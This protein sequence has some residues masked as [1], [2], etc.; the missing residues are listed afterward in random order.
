MSVLP[1]SVVT[2]ATDGKYSVKFS[3]EWKIDN[4]HAYYY[5]S[6]TTEPRACQ[7]E[8]EPFSSGQQDDSLVWSVKVQTTR[9]TIDVIQ[10]STTG[11]AVTADFRCF[12]LDSGRQRCDCIRYDSFLGGSSGFGTTLTCKV[13]VEQRLG[14]INRGILEDHSQS[15]LPNGSLTLCLEI[16]VH[17]PKTDE[18]Q[19]TSQKKPAIEPAKADDSELAHDLGSLLT[20]G[21]LSNVTIVAGG[22]EFKAHKAIL[23]ARSPVFRAMFEHDMREAI[24]NQVTIED[25]S[26]EVVQE[27]LTFVYTG[28]SPNLKGMS[29]DLL[30]AADKYDLKQ[31]KTRSERELADRLT[32]GN[33]VET[34]LLAHQHS[35][36]ELMT[37]CMEK[38]PGYAG[39]VVKTEDW[40]KLAQVPELMA[41]I[42]VKLAPK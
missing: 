38:F 17:R 19:T 7:L 20:D 39:E 15:L 16:L 11:S 29:A 41:K 18:P 30:R 2:K 4:F 5:G 9:L 10:L 34:V 22:K 12:V 25:L 1:P 40:S 27:V 3:H 14:V 26:P 24:K 32:P 31:L 21:F 35:A 33:F 36:T 23:S 28:Q 6:G 8:S 13:R 37:V 42:V